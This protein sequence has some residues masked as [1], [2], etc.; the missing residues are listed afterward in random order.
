M[1]NCQILEALGVIYIVESEVL[2]TVDINLHLKK[3][4]S[5]CHL[6]VDAGKSDRYR[7]E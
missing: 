1:D 6:S 2:P 5:R 4:N 7:V 3:V